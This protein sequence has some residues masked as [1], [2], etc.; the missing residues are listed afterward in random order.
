MRNGSDAQALVSLWL[1]LVLLSPP[2]RLRVD[3]T[4]VLSPCPM[5]LLLLCPMQ[6]EAWV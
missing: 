3:W 4:S 1:V 5:W 6:P 2:L